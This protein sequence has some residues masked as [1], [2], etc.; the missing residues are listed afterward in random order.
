MSRW[1]HI[2]FTKIRVQ[3]AYTDQWKWEK[4][5]ENILSIS[6]L[7]R[8]YAIEYN[9]IFCTLQSIQFVVDFP[10]SF[11]F[12]VVLK[13]CARASFLFVLMTF[14]NFNQ[15]T[16]DSSVETQINQVMENIFYIKKKYGA[17]SKESLSCQSCKLQNHSLNCKIMW[18]IDE[19][20]THNVIWND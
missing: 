7:L 8:I 13:W 9:T 5:C 17:Y 10:F 14:V 15:C 12:A 6:K 16:D 1:A 2:N 4:K 19:N 3:N 18:F 11:S 20:W